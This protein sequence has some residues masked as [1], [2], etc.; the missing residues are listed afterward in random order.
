MAIKIYKD[1]GAV[2]DFFYKNLTAKRPSKDAPDAIWFGWFIKYASAILYFKVGEKYH[3]FIT[4]IT[5]FYPFSLLYRDSLI[6]ASNKTLKR[7]V[8]KMESLGSSKNMH[9]LVTGNYYSEPMFNFDVVSFKPLDDKDTKSYEK[10]LQDSFGSVYIRTE[11]PMR[12]RI[13]MPHE[14]L[15]SCLA[16]MAD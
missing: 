2:I 13:L 7:L 4:W 9:L 14:T 12:F 11:S 16:Q 8:N 3:I 15:R 1:R 5:Q 6:H 10:M